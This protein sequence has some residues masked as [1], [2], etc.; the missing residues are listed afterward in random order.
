MS[1][2]RLA[3]LG[4][5]DVGNGTQGHICKSNKVESQAGQAGL[6]CL[7]WG[8]AGLR[9]A[10]FLLGPERDIV[11]DSSDEEYIFQTN[12]AAGPGASLKQGRRL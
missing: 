1:P 2:R 12:S 5:R 6:S 7:H 8:E 3:G 11:P 9:D 4:C 10:F